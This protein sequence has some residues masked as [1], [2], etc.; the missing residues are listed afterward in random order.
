[1]EGFNKEKVLDEILEI[2]NLGETPTRSAQFN[3]M[4]V[5]ANYVETLHLNSYK[6]GLEAGLKKIEIENDSN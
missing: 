5:A 2:F 1:M 4:I 6:E 3:A